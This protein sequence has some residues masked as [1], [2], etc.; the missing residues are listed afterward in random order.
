MIICHSLCST[1]TG[2]WMLVVKIELFRDGS[3]AAYTQCNLLYI[4]NY[5]CSYDIYSHNN[6]I[7]FFNGYYSVTKWVYL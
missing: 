2:G 3:V 7:R 4:D 6:C 5:C 1:E